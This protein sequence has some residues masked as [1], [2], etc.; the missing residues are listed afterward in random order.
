MV[1]KS[2][3]PVPRVAVNHFWSA[4]LGILIGYVLGGSADAGQ[5]PVALSSVIAGTPTK[6]EDLRRRLTT[7][8]QANR[9][10]FERFTQ[11]EQR[12]GGLKAVAPCRSPGANVD[13]GSSNRD[14][15]L[16]A[17][18]VRD[19]GLALAVLQLSIATRTHQPFVRELA[20]VRRLGAEEARLRTPLDNLAP[21]AT[22]GVATVAELRDS[23]GIILLPKL[24][25]LEEESNVSWSTQAWLWFS[26][27][28]DPAQQP[29]P[30]LV[31]DLR[32][33]LVKSAMERLSEDDLR[34][35]VELITQLDGAWAALTA[36]W[37]AEANARL[38]LDSAY[39]AL[40]STILALLGRISP[41]SVSNLFGVY[42]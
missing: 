16:L 5:Q 4:V 38:S 3:R 21:Y 14:S 40:S 27:T 1:L 20:L 30:P 36:R 25:A 41:D 28:I 8:E 19:Q 26:T 6:M 35:A 22:T 7:L 34:S 31:T 37:L 12:L 32:H 39:E 23:F 11:I 13:V 15:V 24:I 29:T 9:T 33:K 10:I 17:A 18:Q 42:P 2:D